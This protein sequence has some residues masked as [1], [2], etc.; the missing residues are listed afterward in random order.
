[1]SSNALTFVP[2]VRRGLGGAINQ[3]PDAEGRPLFQVKAN[4]SY[5][6]ADGVT[7]SAGPHGVDLK[8]YGPGDVKSLNDAYVGRLE[9]K[10]GTLDF[11]PNYI[12]FV[13]FSDAA[14]PWL[15]SPTMVENGELLPWLC[16]LV[17]PVAD[18]VSIRARPP[19]P[20]PVLTIGSNTLGAA[21]DFQ[22]PNLA[23]TKWWA[24]TQVAG[25]WAQTAN[26]LEQILDT[27]P[28]R[29]TS[30]VICP[31]K[32][33][34]ETKYIAC[35]VPTYKRG[36]QAGLGQTVDAGGLELAWPDPAQTPV[37]SLTLPVYFSWQFRTGR[38]GDFESL[39]R[40]LE[41]F[42]A[43]DNLGA[44]S[45]EVDLVDFG[46]ADDADPPEVR[47][48]T[49][50][51]QGVLRTPAQSPPMLSQVDADIQ[52]VFDDELLV[53]EPR[54]ARPK[55]WAF[56]FNDLES[57]LS[58]PVAGTDFATVE[59]LQFRT[60]GDCDFQKVSSTQGFLYV[61]LGGGS[62]NEVAVFDVDLTT[63]TTER[64]KYIASA[65]LSGNPGPAGS[66][67]PWVAINP[68][69][70]LLYSSAFYEEAGELE[71]LVYQPTVDVLNDQVT[72]D[73]VGRM[74]LFSQDGFR[75]PFEG[76]RIQG[77]T[78]ST[79]G[80]LYLVRDSADSLG[81]IHAFEMVSGRQMAHIPIDTPFGSNEG[82]LPT[83]QTLQGINIVEYTDPT[84]SANV[85]QLHVVLSQE[86][87]TQA[88]I[89]HLGVPAGE[90][91]LI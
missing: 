50:D 77:G 76:K 18:D 36:V 1:M 2:W 11:E 37:D 44:M 90:E 48:S 57:P 72:L 53:L 28:E 73:F 70:G 55:V 64:F 65:K 41:P 3:A 58:A 84:D 5:T 30:R 56:P 89:K 10:R 81:G 4:V 71:L 59:D 68:R 45:L 49:I 29:V 86:N 60:F 91:N 63:G 87:P 66:N 61:P 27:S 26:E 15:F 54:S 82:A 43:Q 46:L 32:L 17:V 6:S 31:V 21:S 62:Y 33:K 47:Y 12:P 67:A 13:E 25:Q 38:A 69:N 88:T 52:N 9:P 8:G 42:E 39:A 14:L 78:F 85:A 7:S 34:P 80:H 19:A 51:M 16:L 74:P 22:L 20:N 79:E 24:H 23:T 35:L 83:P 40:R 75:Q